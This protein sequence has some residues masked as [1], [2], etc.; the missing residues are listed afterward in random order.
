MRGFVLPVAAVARND[1]DV[2]C[3]SEISVG[4]L[5]VYF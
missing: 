5:H 1:S 4:N 3:R 2:C